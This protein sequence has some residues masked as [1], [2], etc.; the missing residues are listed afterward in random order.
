[1]IRHCKIF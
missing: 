1:M